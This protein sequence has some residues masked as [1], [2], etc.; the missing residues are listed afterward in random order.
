MR[1]TGF[2]NVVAQNVAAVRAQQRNEKRMNSKWKCC[3]RCQ[4]D[5]DPRGGF[6]R[7]QAGLHKFICKDCMNAK[8]KQLEE[9]TNAETKTT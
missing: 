8:Q 4:K 6:L 2:G 5:K 9:K 1:G 7:I 3:W